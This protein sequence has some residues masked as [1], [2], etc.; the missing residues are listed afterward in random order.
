MEQNQNEERKLQLEDDVSFMNE[1]SVASAMECTGLMPSLPATE[2]EVESYS[3]IYSVP[4][5]RQAGDV[6]IRRKSRSQKK[7]RGRNS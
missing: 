3:N 2:D 4:S 5:P 6:E 7:N 1:Q